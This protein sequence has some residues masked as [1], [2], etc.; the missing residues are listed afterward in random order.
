MGRERPT[1]GQGRGQLPF[2]NSPASLIPRPKF[3]NSFTQSENVSSTLSTS[4]QKQS[5]RDEAIRRKIEA[6]LNKIKYTLS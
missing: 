1:R 4:Q 2:E 6:D 3:D 5:K